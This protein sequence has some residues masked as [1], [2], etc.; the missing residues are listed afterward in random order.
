MDT[1]SWRK[2]FKRIHPGSQGCRAGHCR[3]KSGR[4][5]EEGRVRSLGWGKVWKE[6]RKGDMRSLGWGKVLK[7]VREGRS[8]L[9]GLGKGLERSKRREE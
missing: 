6:V 5:V 9:L 3:G 2:H 4:K 7:G 1:A 8:E